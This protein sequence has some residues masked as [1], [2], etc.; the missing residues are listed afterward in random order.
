MSVELKPIGD[1]VLIKRID[2]D[3]KTDSGIILPIP[4]QKAL[5]VIVGVGK[6]VL[7]K[8]TGIY[9]NLGLNK[10]DI[11][12]FQTHRGHN[13][14]V[15]N[16]ELM[17]LGMNNILCVYKKEDLKDGKMDIKITVNESTNNLNLGV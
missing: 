3:E 8:R 10:G 2:S 14:N 13:A 9:N 7:N 1:L 15:N 5:G 6:G 11:V 4:N 12:V 16:E 17:L